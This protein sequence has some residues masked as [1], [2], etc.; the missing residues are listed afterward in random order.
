MASPLRVP[1]PDGTAAILWSGR[2]V[3]G[4]TN[5][6]FLNQDLNNYVY[7]G[8]A[9]NIMPDSDSTIPIP[10]NG[11]IIVDASDPWY[12]TGAAAGIQPLVVVP[13]GTGTFL[14]LTQGMGDLAIPSVQSPDFIAG[15]QG[16]QIAQD[17]SAEFNNLTFRGTFK[18]QDFEINQAGEFFYSGTPSASNL[19]LSVAGV[20][21]E[22]PF[23]T[24][25]PSGVWVFTPAG[26]RAGMQISGTNV[27]FFMIPGGLSFLTQ[28]PQLFG[29]SINAGA[30]NE[31]LQVSLLSGKE[32]GN[33]DAGLQLFSETADGTAGARAVIEFGGTVVSTFSRAGQRV[34]PG[35]GSTYRTERATQSLTTPVGPVTSLTQVFGGW[36]V[37]AGT[38]RVHGQFY[39]T[40]VAGAELELYLQAPA[41]AGGQLGY[42]VSRATV[43]LGSVA[44]NVNA[45]VQLAVAMGAA[46]YIVQF[47]GLVTVTAAGLM[48]LFTGSG[49]SDAVTMNAA[50]FIDIFPQ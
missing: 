34:Q 27:S 47:D 46:T 42:T 3:T 39:V 50:S 5:L 2:P 11:S 18:G 40:A 21:G 24:D 44:G 30:A 49:T 17:G 45:S 7:V 37:A 4:V 20:S 23:G 29:N 33:D 13:N 25:V 19:L 15:V 22:D 8:Q 31:E 1:V 9:S 36:N 32:S 48:T 26:A 41:G 12:V 16:W 35:D 38:Y 28:Y 6:L 14:G 43:F 10:P